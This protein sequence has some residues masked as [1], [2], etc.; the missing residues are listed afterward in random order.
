MMSFDC[1]SAKVVWRHVIWGLALQFGFALLV[2]RWDLGRNVLDCLSSKVSSFLQQANA[3]SSFVYG[4]LVN[5]MVTV[6][7]V[8]DADSGAHLLPDDA[9]M[10]IKVVLE[11]TVFAFSV[12]LPNTTRNDVK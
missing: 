4:Y 10:R 9:N 7:N 12:R 2:L 3:G 5:G 11:N 8:T 1:W 6:V